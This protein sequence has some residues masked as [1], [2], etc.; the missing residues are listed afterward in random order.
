[1][2][3]IVLLFLFWNRTLAKRV[4]ERTSELSR[5][6]KLL[7]DE[8]AERT[9]AEELLRESRDYLKNLTDSLADAVFSVKM[10]ERK[11][12]WANDI[13]KVF[14]YEPDECVGRTTEF[15]YPSRND[16]IAFGDKLTQAIAEG[17]DILHTE[18]ILIKK[19]GEVFQA[20]IT[21][22]IYRKEGAV[23]SV[24]VIV[25]NI[26]D[27][28]QKERQLQEYQGRL[29]A[30]AA[31]LTLVEEKERR[32]IA[33]DLHDQIGQSLVLARMQIVSAKKSA[34]DAGL[35]AKLDDISETLREAVHDT[36]HLM[37]ELSSP[38]MHSIGLR[39]AISE[40]LEEEMGKRYNLK[41]KFIDNIDEGQT[42]VLDENV[43]AILFRN[44]RELLV[45]VVKHAQASQ[46]SI[47]MEHTNDALKIVVQDDGIGFDSRELSQ[48]GGITGG[49]GL[50]SIEERMSDLGGVL[51]I[52]SQ[53][54]KGCKAILTVPLRSDD[55][56]VERN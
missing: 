43:R 37:F 15:L 32:R 39:A 14:G 42:K 29:K 8:V 34:T 30:L 9:K 18:Q 36:R 12:E 51:E 19:S 1:A 16:F 44:V 22:T 46:V 13:F 4:K 56:G 20:E 23:V 2:S 17:K 28:K 31:Q 10:P 54:G 3:G 25:R 50:F 41:T 38:T 49:F 47:L 27:R 45:N 48:T 24:T 21:L 52:E 40:W 5:S 53:P 11:I 7:E 6:H 35:T 33:A 55:D 26:A